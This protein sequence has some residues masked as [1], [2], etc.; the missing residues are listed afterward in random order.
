MKQFIKISGN[1]HL[2]ILLSGL[3]FGLIHG[4]IFK[5]LPIAVLGIML[6]YLYW[7]TKNLWFPILAHF[8]NNGIQVVLYFFIARGWTNINP[9]S[10]E[11]VPPVATALLTVLF[12]GAMYLFYNANLKTADESI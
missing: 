12:A 1:H 4:Q 10:A 5:F 3:L 11:I 2:G 6:G 9:E 7:W 8:F